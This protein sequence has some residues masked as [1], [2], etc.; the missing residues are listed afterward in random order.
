M[1]LLDERV[2]ARERLWDLDQRPFGLNHRFCVLRNGTK[3]HYVESIQR[4]LSTSSNLI[5]FLH[6]YPDSYALWTHYMRNPRLAT[7]ATMIAVD[8][9]GFGGSDSM[10]RYGPEQVMEA[11]TE[12]VLKMREQYLAGDD[13]RV[14]IVA[15]DW[16][17]MVGFR[18]AAEAPQLADR[19]LMSNCIHPP[20]AEANVRSRL[21]SAKQML[22]TWLTNPLNLR[23]F[24]RAFSNVWPLIRQI[25]KSGYVFVF[26]LPYGMARIPGVS[27]S[28]M[29]VEAYC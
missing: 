3:L 2:T 1:D 26:N 16:G 19:F 5:I 23:L 14:I 25:V 27:T 15:H 8:L 22:K 11:I 6:G 13:G 7:K 17:A 24:R 28:S 9:P 12:F 10:E 21:V 4:E 20:L 18:L 29:S